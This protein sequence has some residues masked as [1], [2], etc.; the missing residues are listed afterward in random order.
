MSNDEL[1]DLIEDRFV[2]FEDEFGVRVKFAINIDNDGSSFYLDLGFENLPI[3]DDSHLL[4]IENL[5][6]WLE[7]YLKMEA[8]LLHQSKVGRVGLYFYFKVA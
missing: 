2:D 4:K 3:I 1:K 7:K 6:Q 8:E 5:I